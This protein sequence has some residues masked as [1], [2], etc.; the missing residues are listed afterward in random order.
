[1]FYL[2]IKVYFNYNSKKVA[3]LKLKK[4]LVLFKT[5]NH[6]T[7]FFTTTQSTPNLFHVTHCFSL[8]Y[9]VINIVLLIVI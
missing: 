6:F 8:L 1:M 7:Y 4:I 2:L 9:L 3:V 5:I